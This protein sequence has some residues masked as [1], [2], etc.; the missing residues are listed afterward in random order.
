MPMA[1][2]VYIDS[3]VHTQAYTS[4]KQFCFTHELAV[5]IR[6]CPN[7]IYLSLVSLASGVQTYED[8]VDS[9]DP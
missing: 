1:M 5:H 6:R 9:D 7:N 3:K 4:Y 8:S 2:T